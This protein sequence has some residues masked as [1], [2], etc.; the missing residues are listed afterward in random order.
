MIR[1]FVV[2]VLTLGLVGGLSVAA[3]SDAPNPI[4][5][6]VGEANS[7]PDS[8]WGSGAYVEYVSFTA[9]QTADVVLVPP[10]Y[11]GDPAHLNDVEYDIFDYAT[12]PAIGGTYDGEHALVTVL[13][14]GAFS[15]SGLVG[16]NEMHVIEGHG[17]AIAVSSYNGSDAGAVIGLGDTGWR[18][19]NGIHDAPGGP[20][21]TPTP[22]STPTADPTTAPHVGPVGDAADPYIVDPSVGWGRFQLATA[23]LSTLLLA[24]LTFRT[25]ASRQGGE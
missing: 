16:S 4:N 14:G 3:W 7:S 19:Q 8:W 24:L 10:T 5:V 25:Y 11:D 20:E 23:A 22:T 1:L 9:T 6:T 21:P 2:L 13:G 18:L 12:R 15:G 17:Y